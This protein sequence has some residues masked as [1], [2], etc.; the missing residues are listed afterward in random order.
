MEI[1]IE[2]IEKKNSLTKANPAAKK[3]DLQSV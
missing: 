2:Q 1:F 3:S